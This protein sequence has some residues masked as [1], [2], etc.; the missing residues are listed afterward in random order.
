MA[1]NNFYV[2]LILQ[3]VGAFVGTYIGARYMPALIEGSLKYIRR[4]KR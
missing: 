3:S 4:D 1:I 2:F